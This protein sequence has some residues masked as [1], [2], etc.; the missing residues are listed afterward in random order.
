VLQAY[1]GHRVICTCRASQVRS[2]VELGTSQLFQIKEQYQEKVDSQYGP[3]S[4]SRQ[5][6]RLFLQSSEL[7]PPP[8]P[9]PSPA[10][11][12]VPTLW[13]RGEGTHSLAGEGVGGPYSD[14]G[15]DTVGMYFVARMYTAV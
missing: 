12:S 6:T 10:S 1:T 11:E 15:T 13:F 7:G 9:T 5:S 8:A 3:E 14:E 4:Q 2:Q